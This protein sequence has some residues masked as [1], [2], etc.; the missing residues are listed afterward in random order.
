[1]PHSLADNLFF[2]LRLATWTIITM[3]LLCISPICAHRPAFLTQEDPSSQ[4]HPT[5]LRPDW[6][7][8]VT[9]DIPNANK[10]PSRPNSQVAASRTEKVSPSQQPSKHRS[11]SSY[12]LPTYC[13]LSCPIGNQRAWRRAAPSLYVSFSVSTCPSFFTNDYLARN[14]AYNPYNGIDDLGDE[15]PAAEDI[16]SLSPRR[17]SKLQCGTTS[18][19]VSAQL[20]DSTPLVSPTLSPPVSKTV[21]PPSFV[22]PPQNPLSNTTNRGRQDD[23]TR[24]RYEHGRYVERIQ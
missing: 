12:F 7:E 23:G 1:M 11:T 21:R 18:A 13:I 17:L 2:G 22:R 19:E 14:V 20:R 24:N 3:V 8:Q 5:G 15:R 9:K 10:R 6:L 16:P 4:Q